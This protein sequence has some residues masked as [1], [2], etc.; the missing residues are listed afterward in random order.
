MAAPLGRDLNLLFRGMGIEVIEGY[1]LTETTAP[2]TGNRVGDNHAG[3]R[4]VGLLSPIFVYL[5]LTRVSGIPLLDR[6]AQEK[7][8]DDP[9]FQAYQRQTPVLLPRPPAQQADR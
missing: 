7:W 6:K 8:G 2:L 4:Y 1:G 5:L 9:E 3:W